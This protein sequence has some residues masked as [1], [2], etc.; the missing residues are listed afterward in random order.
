MT[1]TAPTT[2]ADVLATTPMVSSDSHI[3]EPPDLWEGRTPEHLGDRGP[4]VVRE[5]DGDWWY[6]DG[7]KTMSF[8]GIQTGDRFKGDPDS[9]RTSGT[10][11]DVR[12]AAYDPARYLVENESDGIWG[13]V[14]YPSQ[15]LVLF[16]VP[17]TEVVSAAMRGYNDWLADFCSHDTARLKGIAMVNLDEP[18]EAVAELE[19]AHDRG[20]AGALITVAPP[21]WRPLRDP[22][23]ERFWSVAAE[24]SMPLS[25]H[26]GTDRGDPRAGDRAFVLDVKNVPPSAF[27]NKDFQVRQAFADLILGGV[28]E[29]HPSLRVGTVEHELAWI[30]FFL[31]QMDYTYT[32]RP[33]RGPWHRFA[34]PDA[35]PSH[36]FHR[37]CFASFQEDRVGMAVRE[38]IG[39]G[40][41]MW[42]SDYPHTESTFPRSR[43]ILCDILDGVDA[44]DVVRIVSTNAAELYGFDLPATT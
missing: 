44:A 4:R 21:A 32:D 6:V 28:L 31:D 22:S 36:F 15:G 8:L 3:I 16:S 17:S 19:R 10:F 18:D 41:L 23:L 40:A 20:L 39:V 37:Q 13:S 34:D 9:L 5:D 30:P 1:I 42:G 27:V 25:L 35:R 11:E 43:Q 24:R 33:P 38:F 7:R 26:V 29:R 12:D 2:V 14:I